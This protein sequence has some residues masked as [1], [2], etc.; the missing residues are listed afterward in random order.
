[1]CLFASVRANNTGTRNGRGL[2]G[3]PNYTDENFDVLLTLVEE[4]EPLGSND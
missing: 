4:V 1:M 3:K 2:L